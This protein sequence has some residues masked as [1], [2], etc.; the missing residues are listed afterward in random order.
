MYCD[1]DSVI[2]IQKCGQSSSVT[3]GVKLGDMAN[4]LGSDEHI[5]DLCPVAQTTTPTKL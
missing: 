2:Y 3:C 5:E 4:D 1:I